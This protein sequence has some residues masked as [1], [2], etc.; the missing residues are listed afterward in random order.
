MSKCK[1]QIDFG[2]GGY[3][4]CG[5]KYGETLVLCDSCK[6]VNKMKVK[7]K[8]AFID[9]CLSCGVTEHAAEIMFKQSEYSE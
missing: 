1:N 7:I 9:G 8:E 2:Q 4:N 3:M 6:T 5:D